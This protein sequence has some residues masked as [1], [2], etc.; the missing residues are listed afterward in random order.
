[1]KRVERSQRWLSARNYP[2][3]RFMP[4]MLVAVV[5][6]LL[7]VSTPSKQT[8]ADDVAN[9]SGSSA[10]ALIVSPEARGNVTM[11]V[12]SPSGAT[13]ETLKGTNGGAATEPGADLQTWDGW[14]K[15][16]NT[17][18]MFASGAKMHGVGLTA[19]T[20]SG[21]WPNQ[22]ESFTGTDTDYVIN[23]DYS[24]VGYYNFSTSGQPNL[25][26][27]GAKVTITDIKYG[28]NP[29]WVG[30]NTVPYILFSDN[31]YSGVK[32]GRIKSM[33]ISLSFYEAD[34]KQVIDFDGN[35]AVFSFNS[36]NSA[37]GSQHDPEGSTEY[38]G[39]ADGSATGKLSPNSLLSYHEGGITAAPY[40]A[41]TYYG[42][43][44][45]FDDN[46]GSSMFENATVT[47]PLKGKTN[48]FKFG[49]VFGAA[50]NAFSSSANYPTS[51]TAP[52]KT[53]EPLNQYQAGD[54]WNHPTG[55][56]AGFDQRYDNDLDR[57]NDGTGIWSYQNAQP[58]HDPDHHD[59]NAGIPAKADRYVETGKEYYYYINQ[60]TI[61]LQTQGLILPNGYEIDDTLPAGTEVESV[62]LYN[63][64]GTLIDNAFKTQPQAGTR[65]LALTLTDSATTAINDLSKQAGYYGKDFTV[66][67]KFKVTNTTSD[68]IPDLMV[69]QASSKFFYSSLNAPYTATSNLVHIRVKDVTQKLNFKKVAEDGSLLQGATFDLIAPNGEK[70]NDTAITSDANGLFSVSAKQFADGTYTLRETKAPAGYAKQDYAVEV[71]AGKIIGGD[72]HVDGGVAKVIDKKQAAKLVLKKR[73]QASQKLL[74]GAEFTLY[75]QGDNGQLGKRV[76]TVTTDSNGEASVDNLDWATNY[77]AVETKAPAGYKLPDPQVAKNWQAITFDKT[78]LTQTLTFDDEL[79]ALSIHLQKVDSVTNQP[80]AG[81]EFELTGPDGYAQ[82]SKSTNDDAADYN[83]AFTELVPGQTYTLKEKHAPAGYV[84]DKRTYPV[85]V[86]AD[87]QTVKIADQTFKVTAKG[88]VNIAGIFELKNDPM[89]ILPHT[90][91]HGVFNLVML[92]LALLTSAAGLL[93]YQRR[94]GDRS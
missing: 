23:L 9:T 75:Q 74:A 65:N 77:W 42:S 10:S 41:G 18:K 54:T 56:A 76:V 43:S 24:N 32:Y 80:L 85:V 88:N 15:T 8:A 53:V 45:D 26:P 37:Q 90:G 69:N 94:G 33:K 68:D 91:G 5:M 73:D 87:G 50:W 19:V 57:Y 14:K 62:E 40:T 27:V 29:S 70:V 35:N 11:S 83:L 51:Q 6:M 89:T 93:W 13:Y 39:V 28:T 81:A 86:A 16:T 25:K 1:M 3:L 34:T 63:L 7:V 55:T 20:P 64:N 59:L 48:T 36:L 2:V 46:L 52:S 82:T 67:V 66:R 38:A 61:N 79:N 72:V 47:F 30:A 31:L 60:P 4:W 49:S 44:N 58:G 22:D 17:Y 92:A 21:A 71:K 84:T 78:T 12:S